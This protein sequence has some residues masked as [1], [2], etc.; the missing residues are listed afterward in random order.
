MKHIRPD[1]PKL[2]ITNIGTFDAEGVPVGW[3]FDGISHPNSVGEYFS[4]DWHLLGGYTFDELMDVKV[5]FANETVK[6]LK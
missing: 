2:K 3:A 1:I 6:G 5:A 4:K